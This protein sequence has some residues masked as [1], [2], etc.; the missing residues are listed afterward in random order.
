MITELRLVVVG[1][2][3][4]AE[5]FLEALSG[6]EWA[7]E[8]VEVL[9]GRPEPGRTLSYRQRAVDVNPAGEFD[10]SSADLAVFLDD[11]ACAEEMAD[12]AA[13]A[14]CM[15]V[16]A[17]GA[18]SGRPDVP[19]V[20]AE[21]DPEGVLG[22]A[23]DRG[24]VSV[25]VAP[26]ALLARLLVPLE[27]FAGVKA[28]QATALRGM[29]G[30]GGAAV[31]ELAAQTAALLNAQQRE[32]AVFDAAVAFNLLP[33]AGEAEGGQA[34]TEMAMAESVRRFLARETLPVT[35]SAVTVPV[36]HGDGLALHVELASGVDPRG[37]AGVL[38]DAGMAAA[39][40][41]LG[42]DPRGVAEGEGIQ[43]G[44]IRVIGE[45]GCHLALWAV[46]D[47]VRGLT[48]PAALTMIGLLV[49]E[50]A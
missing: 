47:P 45:D 42:P 7:P 5:G 29:S 16:E 41:P 4:A 33:E 24:L 20:V 14:G 49:Q 3:P 21:L 22:A 27:Q 30:Y 8:M 15:V 9:A 38:R 35:A 6:A 37:I 18:V 13:A 36:F 46:A 34:A 44:R 1:D 43:V 23:L 50:L 31:E 19:Q 25:P 10:F 12:L 17:T 39:D 32:P 40:G 2:G 48:V 26:A 11:A 28:V